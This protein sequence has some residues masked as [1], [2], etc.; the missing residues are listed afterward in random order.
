MNKKK[1]LGLLCWL[2]AFAVP[3]RFALLNTESVGNIQGL[4]SF[5]IMIGMIFIGY[6]LVDSSDS[7]KGEATDHH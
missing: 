7:K 3:F 1:I 6:A 2:A 4:I 5:V